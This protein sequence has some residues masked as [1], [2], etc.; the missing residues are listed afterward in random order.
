M[1]LEVYPHVLGVS[2]VKRC[3][4]CD[5]IKSVDQFAKNRCKPDGLQNHC[6]ACNAEYREAHRQELRLYAAG[7][8]EQHRDRILREMKARYRNNRDRYLLLA[9]VR[10][11]KHRDRILAERR[12]KPEIAIVQYHRRKARKL[13][14]G[15]TFTPADIG[16]IRAA[17]TDR[18]GRVR[19]WWC[20]I[21]M[22]AWHVD[23][24]F[25][26]RRGGRN[27]AGNL[28]LSCAD[29]NLKKHAKTPAEFAGRLI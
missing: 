25:P 16:A 10:H 14:N 12:A 26:L 13:A 7:Y 11:W 20:G 17:Q 21:P 9:M 29:C 22:T 27:D 3:T 28:C 1:F 5:T 15:G 19:C 18:R 24:K 4:G 2:I 8:H 23:H 6:K